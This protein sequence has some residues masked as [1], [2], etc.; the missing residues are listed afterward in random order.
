MVW[1]T[2]IDLPGHGKSPLPTAT[3]GMADFATKVA[4]FI[5]E[6]KLQPVI[7]IGHSVGGKTS[8]KLASLYPD[9]VE[10]IILINSWLLN[11]RRTLKENIRI[12]CI[13]K[14]GKILKFFK[15]VINLPYYETWFIKKFASAD[16]QSA[17]VMKDT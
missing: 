9:L 15:K 7:L 8:L 6:K 13:H 12:Y 10:K 14:T 17:G 2:L 16:Y 4:D 3:W 5:K 1:I 11:V